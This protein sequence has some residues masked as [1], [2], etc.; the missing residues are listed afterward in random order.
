MTTITNNATNNNSFDMTKLSQDTI[1][2]LENIKQIDLTF[3]E[4][5]KLE[6]QMKVMKDKIDKYTAD[7]IKLMEENKLP[8]F[9]TDFFKF[10]I[11]AGYTRKVV[12]N[13]KLKAD[14]LYDSYLKETVTKPTL[15]REVKD[16][17]DA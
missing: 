11:R 8:V 13:D 3:I 14:G 5:T 17:L 9:V 2:T 12:D 1:N 16:L 6:R 7:I 4:Y 15:H 10:T